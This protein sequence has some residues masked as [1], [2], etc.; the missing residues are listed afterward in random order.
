ML[1][2]SPSDQKGTKTVWGRLNTGGLLTRQC[3]LLHKH[4]I[5]VTNPKH[6]SETLCLKAWAH[7]TPDKPCVCSTD[8]KLYII[9]L[10]ITHSLSAVLHGLG[11]G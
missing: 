1:H 2:A 6:G 9:Q 3:L 4:Q 7:I 10:Y 5:S 8:E 11:P